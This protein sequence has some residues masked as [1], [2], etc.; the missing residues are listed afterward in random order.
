MAMGSATSRRAGH[1]L[2][3]GNLKGG[4]GKSTLA[5]NLACA[6]AAAGRRTAIMDC[7][8]QGTAVGWAARGTAPVRVYAEPLRNLDHAPDWLDRTDWLRAGCDVLVIDLPA[9]IAPAMAASFLMASV[10]LIP[11]VPNAV[12]IDGTRRVLALLE[13]AARER[14][15]WPPRALVVPVRVREM[16]AG[17]ED[18]RTRLVRLGLPMTG[19]VRHASEFDMAYAMGSWVGDKFRGSRANHELTLLADRVMHEIDLAPPRPAVAQPRPTMLE[20]MLPWWR[21]LL[22]AAQPRTAALSG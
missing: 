8:P 11:A 7:D 6:M 17:L 15:G 1:V 10:I 5:M 12:D 14:P 19:P 4:S 16:E 2:V 9:V 20:P 3:V 18:W 21:R 22:A 13:T